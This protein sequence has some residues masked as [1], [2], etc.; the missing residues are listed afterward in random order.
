MHLILLSGENL[1]LARIEA[2]TLLKLENTQLEENYLFCTIPTEKMA[3][4]NRLSYTRKVY[5]IEYTTHR[6]NLQASLK[7]YPWINYYEKNFCIR[8]TS[9][10]H[11][12]ERYYATFV[13]QS[14][15]KSTRPK[16]NLDTPNLLIEIFINLDRAIVT[17]LLYQNFETFENRKAHLRPVLHPTAMHP[18]MARA[19]INILNPKPNEKILDPC[20]GA[21]GILTE[22]GLLG[23]K[24]VG[25]DI[26]KDILEDAKKNMEYYNIKS[27]H[28]DLY[29]K[30][31][32]KITN[33]KNIVTD[34][35]YG[36]SSKKS[37]DL[38]TL[39]AKLLKNIN[40]RAVIV[41]PNFMPY[42]KLLNKNLSKSLE[43]K[44][45]IDHYVHKSLTRKIIIIDTI[46]NR[47]YSKNKIKT[48]PVKT[49][50][51][52]ITKKITIN[53]NKTSTN[54]NKNNTHT[55][56]KKNI[57]DNKNTLKKSKKSASKS[58]KFIKHIKKKIINKNIK[59]KKE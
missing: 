24:F 30:D 54:N 20:C 50:K 38:I 58:K 7:E 52:I 18:K 12:D 57:K 25:Y 14:L 10:E 5:E 45:I 27:D 13:W 40:G 44:E 37:E 28:Y 32:T 49:R 17:R 33:L 47:K 21:C 39:Y 35:P 42:K 26:N 31:S 3:L 53:K 56:N 4:I 19:L 6:K 1:K 55:K 9:D 34:L 23:I 51:K 11:Y 43:V 48:K 2:E 46:Q 15:E 22:A 29:V 16:V 59:S 36:K 8:I 41:M